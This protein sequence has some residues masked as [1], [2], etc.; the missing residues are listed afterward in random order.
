MVV[1]LD[2]IF[3]H[4]DCEN[5][6]FSGRGM[7][8]WT[9]ISSVNRLTVEYR[10]SGWSLVYIKKTR[11]GPK[12]ESCGTP[13]IQPL[14][15]TTC[16]LFVRNSFIRLFVLLLMP[17]WCS[18][19]RNRLWE[20]LSKAFEKFSISRSV[21]RFPDILWYRQYIQGVVFRMNF[22]SWSHVVCYSPLHIA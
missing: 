10:S 12:T 20:T 8:K 5:A 17:Y 21:F 4:C 14:L 3:L 2:Y 11:L 22:Y 13:R 19:Y 16:V 18:L 7:V 9:T 6:A 15:P 1:Q